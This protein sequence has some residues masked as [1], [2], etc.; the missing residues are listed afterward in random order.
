MHAVNYR[1]RAKEQLG[2]EKRM[3][4][5]VK[6]CRD[7]SADTTG[8][9]HITQLRDGRI[10]ENFFDVVLGNADCRREQSSGRAN[11]RDDEH[12]GRRVGVNR[13]EARHQVHAGGDHGGRVNQRRHRR[14][15]FHRVRQP[16][17]QGDLRALS[18]RADEEQHCH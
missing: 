7:E 18:D 1:A 16:D 17:K 4:H 12:C 2:F 14:R 10:R 3:G 15:P 13:M 9:K 8:Q 6:Y 5:Y 11:D